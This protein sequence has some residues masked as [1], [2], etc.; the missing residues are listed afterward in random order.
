MIQAVV[1]KTFF[2]HFF[3]VRPLWQIESGV[4]S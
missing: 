1:A 3:T 4:P 2:D